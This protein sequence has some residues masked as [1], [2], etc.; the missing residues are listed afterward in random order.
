MPSNNS[1]Y[2]PQ[3][4]EET[5]KMLLDT[6]KSST[7]FAE[8]TG[9]DVNTVCKWVRDYRRKHNLPS[10][11]ESKGRKTRDP[12]SNKELILKNKELEKILKQQTK[13]LQD[14]KEKIEILKKSLRIFMLPTE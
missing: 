5:A 7:S 13:Q 12:V 10:Y 1:K 8:E 3:M 11:A 4:R 2:T 9:I 14:E 6:G